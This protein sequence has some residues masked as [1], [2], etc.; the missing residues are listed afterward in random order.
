MS[1]TPASFP[2]KA[3][4]TCFGGAQRYYEHVSSEI[5]LPMKFSVYLPPKAV[6]GEK[7]PALLYLAGM[8]GTVDT[9]MT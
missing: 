3:A 2:L 6:N 9:L 7:V 1:D 5:G 8:T 4:H